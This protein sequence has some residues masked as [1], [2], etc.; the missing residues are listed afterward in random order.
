[1]GERDRVPTITRQRGKLNMSRR[2]IPWLPI[3]IAGL[4]VAALGYLMIS[5]SSFEGFVEEHGHIHLAPH[6]GTLIVLGMHSAHVEI[7][8]DA[9]SGAMDLYVLDGSAVN[10]FSMPAKPI[11]IEVRLLP[12]GEWTTVSLL[13]SE[14]PEF[15]PT[16][17]QTLKFSAVVDFLK[18]VDAF[19]IRLPAMEIAGTPYQGVTTG[20]PEGNE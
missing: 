10:T 16:E 7:V 13:P 20:Y 14:D 11:E 5:G 1:V 3:L 15:R 12:D 17:T 9:A 8:H 6:G 19:G 2:R 18:G 4:I